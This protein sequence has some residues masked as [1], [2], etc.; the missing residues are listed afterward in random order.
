M[1][2]MDKWKC[3]VCGYIYDPAKGDPFKASPGTDFEDLP[4]DWTCPICG[5]TKDKYVPA[6]PDIDIRKRRARKRKQGS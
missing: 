6:P 2:K 3:S 1:Q 4:D 5:V